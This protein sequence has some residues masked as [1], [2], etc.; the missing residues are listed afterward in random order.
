M[1]DFYSHH[2]LHKKAKVTDIYV[3]YCL[4]TVQVSATLDYVLNFAPFVGIAGN[5]L[6]VAWD[7]IHF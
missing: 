4:I 1:L 2:A 6:I 7:F 3:E 5:Q